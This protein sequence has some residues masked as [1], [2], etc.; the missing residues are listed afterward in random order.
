MTHTSSKGIQHWVG[1]LADALLSW[2]YKWYCL[3][4]CCDC[5]D[6]KLTSSLLTED[7]QQSVLVAPSHRLSA[8]TIN[9]Q[10]RWLTTPRDS[11]V[12]HLGP[13]RE[14][15][16]TTPAQ[17]LRDTP[18]H[19]GLTNIMQSCNISSF[20]SHTLIET[21]GS[22]DDNKKST[23]TVLTLTFLPQYIFYPQ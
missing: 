16:L 8:G 18:G 11:S 22:W 20:Y 21:L 1:Q 4:L 17:T 7:G 3:S 9:N 13:N 5:D 23:F 2:D 6:K 15:I 12:L 14:N 19:T 10:T